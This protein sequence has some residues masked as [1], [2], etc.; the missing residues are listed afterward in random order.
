MGRFL[1]CGIGPHMSRLRHL[2]WNQCSHGL[3]SRPLESCHHQCLSAVC[4]VLGY[5]KGSAAE[6]LDGS[7]KLR[8]CTTVFAKQISPLPPL[9][10]PPLPPWSLP[11][12]GNGGGKRCDV[13]PG[14]SSD[15]RSSTV[16]SVRLT[17]KT[18]PS[19][20]AH[21]I[22]DPG[23]STQWANP[24]DKTVSV[25]IP[26]EQSNVCCVRK[27]TLSCGHVLHR[28]RDHR[29]GCSVLVIKNVVTSA[30]QVERS[31]PR[32]HFSPRPPSQRHVGQYCSFTHAR[33][34]HPHHAIEHHQPHYPWLYGRLDFFFAVCLPIGLCH[35]SIA[36]VTQCFL[37]GRCSR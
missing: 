33:N 20:L 1:P 31:T 15:D 19:V 24:Q 7:L 17:R 27:T 37:E 8:F 21:V 28:L 22:P 16:K 25:R 14:H 29:G 11:K 2:G 5:P 26:N 13:T 9:S 23:H 4:G 10:P 32:N 6:L 34:H 12:V 35:V 18:R 3:S 36:M 30:I